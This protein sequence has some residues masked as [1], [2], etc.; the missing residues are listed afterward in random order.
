[1]IG[2]ALSVRYGAN[3]RSPTPAGC[4]DDV[5][6]VEL[7]DPHQGLITISAAQSRRRHP[8][9][10]GRHQRHSSPRR[11]STPRMNVGIVG[12]TVSAGSSMI[13]MTSMIGNAYPAPRRAK[14]R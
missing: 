5:A 13:S 6:A 7:V 1:M 12:T 14:V 2:R 3:F 10:L 4:N 11:L 9:R 8:D